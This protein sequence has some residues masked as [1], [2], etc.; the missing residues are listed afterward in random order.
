MTFVFQVYIDISL[1]LCL[2][3]Y[4]SFFAVLKGKYLILKK[5]L[6][7]LPQYCAATIKYHLMS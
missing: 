7:N 3:M 5:Y 1:G 2:W 6:I 4:V